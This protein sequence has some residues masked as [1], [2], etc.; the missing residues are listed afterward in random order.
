[1]DY[2]DRSNTAELVESKNSFSGFL[3]SSGYENQAYLVEELGN[4]VRG[5]TADTLLAV[6]QVLNAFKIGDDDI[7]AIVGNIREEKDCL[8]KHIR[9]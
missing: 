3:R 5:L 8:A 2:E 1:M 6:D 4:E 9:Y 7:D